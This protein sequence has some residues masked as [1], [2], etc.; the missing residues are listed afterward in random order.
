MG[1]LTQHIAEI[2]RLKHPI[3]SIT[4]GVRP[5]LAWMGVLAS[6]LAVDAATSAAA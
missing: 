4:A 3:A 6:R 2:A 1:N 5:V